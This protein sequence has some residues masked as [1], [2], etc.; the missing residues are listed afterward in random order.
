VPELPDVAVY[1]ERLVARYG[2]ARLAAVRVKSPFVVRTFDPPVSDAVGRSVKDA[3][4]VGKRIVLELEPELHLVFHLMIAGRFHVKPK[5]AAPGKIGLLALD[6]PEETLLFTEASSKKRA[7][8]HVVRTRAEALAMSRGGVEP[9]E[10]SLHE[11]GR[12]LQ[13]EN[14]T[15]KRALTDP[16]LISGVGNAYSDEILFR[17]K[18]SPLKRTLDLDAEELERLFRS[19]VDVLTEWTERLRRQAG[20]GFPEKV[21]AFHPEM[22]VHGRY[23]QPCRVCGAPVQRI[24]Y[25]ENEANYCPNCQTGGRLLADR[26]LSRLLKGDWPR[27][28]EELEELRPSAALEPPTPQRKASVLEK[29]AAPERAPVATAPAPK[30]RAK[31]R[32]KA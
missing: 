31:A 22:S 25:A 3:Y 15:L 18:L 10:V 11:F 27:T 2:G 6:F 21:T 7:S 23:R 13:S 19:T 16:S 29:T 24:V 12:S 1:V 5:G 8:L 9:L 20:D 26:A 32:K 28:L 17:A 30:P 4:R 14:R